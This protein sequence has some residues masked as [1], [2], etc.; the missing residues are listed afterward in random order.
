MSI[1]ALVVLLLFLA[2]VLYL[3]NVKGA[4]MNAT[5]KLLINIVI[6]GV[7]IILVLSAFGVWDEVKDVQVPK[8]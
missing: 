1:I 8:L 2:A 7:A 6:I 5:I 4:S 3:V